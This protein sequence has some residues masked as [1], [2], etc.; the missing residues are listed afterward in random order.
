MVEHAHIT[1]GCREFDFGMS[2]FSVS[3]VFIVHSA[4]TIRHFKI[5]PLWSLFKKSS[6]FIAENAV[7][8]K[9]AGQTGENGCIFKFIWISVCCNLL[10]SD[11]STNNNGWLNQTTGLPSSV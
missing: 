8:V 7:L 4:P 6:V 5:F 1:G 2:T 9:K 11:L 3:S 10:L